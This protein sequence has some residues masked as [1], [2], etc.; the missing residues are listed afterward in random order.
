MNLP[1]R[2]HH[3]LSRSIMKHGILSF[4]ISLVMIP[5]PTVAQEEKPDDFQPGM[6]EITLRVVPGNDIEAKQAT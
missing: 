4:L 3:P 6:H 5:L 2:K 1:S